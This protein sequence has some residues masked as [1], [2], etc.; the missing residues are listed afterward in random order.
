M[1]H[2]IKKRQIAE[3][4][5]MVGGES[6][7]SVARAEEEATSKETE[8]LEEGQKNLPGDHLQRSERFA[9]HSL[10]PAKSCNHTT[11]PFRTTI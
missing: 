10:R 5:R 11:T 1:K 6:I 2:Q 3:F 7:R 9:K 4:S 8:A